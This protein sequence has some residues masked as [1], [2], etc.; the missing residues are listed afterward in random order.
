MT[1]SLAQALGSGAAIATGIIR[2]E[3]GAPVLLRPE[4]AGLAPQISELRRRRRHSALKA[5]WRREHDVARDE[6]AERR[7][8]RAGDRRR[9]ERRTDSDF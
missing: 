3:F 4:W 8:R 1:R 9:G 5:L 2:D 6:G 7:E